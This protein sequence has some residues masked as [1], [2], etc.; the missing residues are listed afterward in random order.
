MEVEGT[1]RPTPSPLIAR[2]VR[3]SPSRLAVKSARPIRRKEEKKMKPERRIEFFLPIK[4]SN[5]EERALPTIAS[6]GGKD[7]AE[8]N[9]SQYFSGCQAD[10][11]TC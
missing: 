4:L 8:V 6:R 3:T 5:I 11:L 1:P 10:L 2:P 9:N 7:T